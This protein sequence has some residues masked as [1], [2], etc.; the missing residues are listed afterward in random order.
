MS[1]VP[2]R[3]P[4]A[5]DSWHT[6]IQIDAA[7]IRHLKGTRLIA[8]CAGNDSLSQIP[9]RQYFLRTSPI[10]RAANAARGIELDQFVTEV[11]V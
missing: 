2:N 1:I 4:L 6:R 5:G 11:S 7:S 10:T 8:V 3:P 9:E